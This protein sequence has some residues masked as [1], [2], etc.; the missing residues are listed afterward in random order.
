MVFQG[1]VARS[2][3][4]DLG[5]IP[6]MKSKPLSRFTFAAMFCMSLSM[7]AWAANTTSVRTAEA[8]TNDLGLTIDII[9]SAQTSILVNSYELTST[10]ITN[11]LLDRINAGIPV[12]ILQEGQPTGGFSG[13]SKKVEAQLVDAMNKQSGDH[14]YLMTSA[15]KKRRY[16]YDHAKYMVIDGAQLLLGSENYSATGNPESGKLGNRGWEVALSGNASIIDTFN[17]TFH[18]DI[19]TSYGDVVEETNNH[20]D[21]AKVFSSLFP[22]HSLLELA[23]Y[24]KPKK[25]TLPPLSDYT[26]VAASDVQPVL[27]PTTSLSGLKSLL[28][29]ATT[30]IDIECM[31]FY[32]DWT[33]TETDSPLYQSVVDAANRGVQV[34]VLL[35]DENA[36]DDGD[37]SET[38][39]NK[40]LD[41]V[42]ALN[43][44]AQQG[45]TVQARIA[46]IKAMGVDY[47]HNKGVLVDD[48]Q[49]LV[50]SIN[51]DSNSV[52][53]NREAALVITSPDVHSH[54]EALFQSDWDDSASS[55]H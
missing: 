50:S 22:M 31:T 36:F 15:T 14:Y 20:F 12:T 43:A 17:E 33:K 49:T 44:L 30:S 47:I 25:G 53:N 41:T 26:P 13:A 6:N 1:T 55:S 4:P 40:N 37:H 35:N 52:L 23:T 34:R 7:G 24:Q 28:D 21:S 8:P 9:E 32:M 18:T 48:N 11:A 45:A 19:D 51:W 54:Y 29:S 27:S 16:R 2:T 46:N 10:E 38:K 3:I 5:D 42:N 39:T